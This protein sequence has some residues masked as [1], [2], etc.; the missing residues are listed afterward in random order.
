MK[1]RIM[2]IVFCAILLVGFAMNVVTPDKEISFT[3]RRPLDQLPVLNKDFIFSKDTGETLEEYLLDQ[4]W[5]RDQFR[6][7]K[8][9]FDTNILHKTDVNGLY[10]IGDHVFKTDYPISENSVIKAGEKMMAIQKKFFGE[11][12]QVAFSMI[13]D[14]AHYAP[15]KDKYLSLD[16]HKMQEL[17]SGSLKDSGMGYVDLE[18]VLD[19]EDYYYTDLHW[20]QENLKETVE[21][22]WAH[23]GIDAEIDINDFTVNQY[24]PFYGAYYGQIASNGEGDTLIWLTDDE[25]NNMIVKDFDEMKA[26]KDQVYAEEKLGTVD[27]YEL[28]FGGNSPLIVIDNPNCETGNRLIL[29]RDSFGSAIAPLLAKEYSQ[30]VLVDLRFL[31]YEY[32]GNFVDFEDADILFMWGQAI[33]N[34]STMIRQR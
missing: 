29:F 11:T 19:L 4:F 18:S 8:V 9:W 30:V 10:Q 31:G 34:D 22:I 3:E 7:L 27:S 26:S 23:F 24:A 16:Y 28:F 20:K 13:P 14:K 2:T 25:I 15:N 5:A 17:L 6:S 1:H 33:Y 32:L 21:A 12:N